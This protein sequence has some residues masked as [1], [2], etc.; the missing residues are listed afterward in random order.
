MNHVEELMQGSLQK[1]E[2]P[3]TQASLLNTHL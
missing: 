2:L 3:M 1:D